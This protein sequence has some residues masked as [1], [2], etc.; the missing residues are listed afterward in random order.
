MDADLPENSIY[1]GLER[2]RLTRA[3]DNALK[4]RKEKM[5]HEAGIKNEVVKA[6][7]IATH[8]KPT[9]ANERA[10]PPERYNQIVDEVFAQVTKLGK[11]KG[12]EYAAG[13]DRLANFRKGAANLDLPMEVIWQV[14]TQKHWDAVSQ[15]VQDVKNNVKRERM[16]SPSG[17]VLDIIVY[18][19]LMLCMMEERDGKHVQTS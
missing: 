4:S 3:F 7:K 17:R 19:L 13:A 6:Q 1:I 9:P 18:L 8:L 5:I 12:D 10:F 2:D 16:E 11:L 15:Y 14:Y